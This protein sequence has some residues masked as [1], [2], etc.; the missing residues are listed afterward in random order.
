MIFPPAQRWDFLSLF[1]HDCSKASLCLIFGYI[2]LFLSKAD[3]LDIFYGNFLTSLSHGD[4][5]SKI[6]TLS[7]Y[8]F[9]VAAYVIIYPSRILKQR[10]PFT[11]P[12]S[13]ISPFPLSNSI[14]FCFPSEQ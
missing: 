13:E 14:N 4:F 3:I 6:S 11:V 2:L 9:S 5:T 10:L 1:P 7:V 8:A 12:L